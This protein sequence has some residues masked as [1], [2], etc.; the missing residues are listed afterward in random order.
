MRSRIRVGF[1]LSPLSRPCGR[2]AGGGGCWFRFIF[3]VRFV[4]RGRTPPPLNGTKRK[5][6]RPHP[7][8]PSRKA[9]R[10][11]EDKRPLPALREGGAKPLRRTGS[12]PPA[13]PARG[14]RA[15]RGQV[16]LE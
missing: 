3:A 16:P 5:R 9:G 2:G 11:E 7:R 12:F 4:Q 6:N 15:G 1:L 14:R 8:P 13:G 10:G